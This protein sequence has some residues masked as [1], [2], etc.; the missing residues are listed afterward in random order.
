[1]IFSKTDVSDKNWNRFYWSLYAIIGWTKLHGAVSLNRESARTV[2]FLKNT[3]QLTFICIVVRL[4]IKIG[5]V[6]HILDHQWYHIP[7]QAYLHFMWDFPEN[8]E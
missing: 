4:T 5:A 8:E 3:V 6:Y 1:M 7:I 2:C